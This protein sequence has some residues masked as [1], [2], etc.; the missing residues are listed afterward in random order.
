MASA[1]TRRQEVSLLLLDYSFHITVVP[2]FPAY[3]EILLFA[4]SRDLLEFI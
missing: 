4:S 3:T 2:V 1:P